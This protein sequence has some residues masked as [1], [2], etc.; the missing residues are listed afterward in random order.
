MF[1]GVAVALKCS[2]RKKAQNPDAKLMLFV[3]SDGETNYGHSLDDLQ[4]I[5][6]T[7]KIPVYTVGY[8]ADIKALQSL[9]SI[10]EAASIN[11]DSEDVVYKLGSLFNAQM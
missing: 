9:S 7:F 2:S 11:A 4:D 8:N 6:K 5:L 1:D 10:N 3:L